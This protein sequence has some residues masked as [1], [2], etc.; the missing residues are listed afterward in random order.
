MILVIAIKNEDSFIGIANSEKYI[1]TTDISKDNQRDKLLSKISEII[2]PK[3]IT[4]IIVFLGPGPF[5][6][7]RVGVSIAN[8]LSYALGVPVAGV[9]KIEDKEE[10]LK[11]GIKIIKEEPQNLVFPFYDKEPNI[12]KSKKC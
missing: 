12:T 3:D 11:M 10:M 2:S 5:T 6:G 4:G 7:V 1:L 8:A 9:K